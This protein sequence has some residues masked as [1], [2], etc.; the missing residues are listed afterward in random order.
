MFYIKLLLFFIIIQIINGVPNM[1]VIELIGRT[2][3]VG[4]KFTMISPKS[5][6]VDPSKMLAGINKKWFEL[7]KIQ[8]AI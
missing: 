3:L 1:E 6:N 5:K 4:I 7:L 8:R 2:P